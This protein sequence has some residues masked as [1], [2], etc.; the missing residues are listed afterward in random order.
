MT[1]AHRTGDGV[2]SLSFNQLADGIRGNGIVIEQNDLPSP[3]DCEP[4]LSDST[5]DIAIDVAAGVAMI[6]G[7][8]HGV[9]TSSAKLSDG[10]STAP[11]RDVVYVS[12][13]G[14]VEV[15][16]GESGQPATDGSGTVLRGASAPLPEAPDMADVTGVPIAVVWIPPGAS[17]SDDLDPGRDVWD[18]RIP[19]PPEPDP[20]LQAQTIPVSELAAGDVRTVYVPVEPGGTIRI[21]KW[22]IRKFNNATDDNWEPTSAENGLTLEFVG[23]GGAA[24]AS[25]NAAIEKGDPIYTASSDT[26][27]STVADYYFRIHNQTGADINSPSGLAAYVEYAVE[28][29]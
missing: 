2:D 8:E 12:E 4:S 25:T 9:A 14:S 18:R 23:P 24:T 17:S 5:S 11:R 26:S 15:L 16:E 27:F 22:G 29:P 21:Y 13:G 1:F 28:E 3:V 10:S 20:A 6:D 7:S 19:V